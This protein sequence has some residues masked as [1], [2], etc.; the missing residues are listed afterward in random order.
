[1]LEGAVVPTLIKLA[2]PA[3]LVNIAQTAIGL[4]ETY[5]V[6]KLGT[7]ALAGVALVFPLVMLAQ[8]LSAGAVGGGISSA[9]ARAL[10]GGRRAD[11]NAL[12][13]HSIAVGA[14]FGVLFS[15]T[16]LL[17]GP[18][19]YA[20][21]G[22]S[23]ASLE[24]ALTYSN[25]IFA[26]AVLIWIYNSLA[27]VIRGTGNMLVPALVTCGGIVGVIPISPWLI[28]GWG[29]FPRLGVAGGSTALLIYYAVGCLVLVAYLRSGRS[30]VRLSLA[31]H[32][33]RRPLFVD[34]LQVGV[35]SALVTLGTNVTVACVT[36]LVGGFGAAAIAGFGV[37]ARLEYLLVPL[38]FGLGA[39]L[40]ALVGTNSGAGQRDRAMRVAWIGALM[41]ALLCELV[42]VLAA[43]YPRAW[44]G[45]F[46]SDQ[47]MLDVGSAYLQTVGPAYGL[48]GLGMGLYFSAQGFG[49]LTWPVIANFTRL[50]LAVG[51]GW[52]ALQLTG[53]VRFVF[54]A[55]SLGLAAFG[56]INAAAAG[57]GAFAR[58]QQ[59]ARQSAS[60]VDLA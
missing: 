10:G 18:W 38:A 49:R 41:T 7:D 58:D 13:V 23:G 2:T 53:D 36:G 26:G 21:L 8:M 24:A 37:G 28:F 4:V 39:P 33:F 50:V 14:L 55:L 5:F 40:V 31:G 57:L 48:F 43:Q 60:S 17:F 1:L 11:A 6:G 35:V 3:L 47:A 25:V 12:V 44:L 20:S 45:L 27:N 54:V 56:L 42:G 29:P 15:A 51:G 32:R 16:V 59:A 30:P 46:G 19:L 22:G 34:I 52:L 9:V